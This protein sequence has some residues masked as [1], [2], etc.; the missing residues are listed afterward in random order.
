M[1]ILEAIGSWIISV[2][3]WIGLKIWAVF[4]YIYIFFMLILGTIGIVIGFIAGLFR[5][6]E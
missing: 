6:K 5:G 4:V 2:V 1:T 3:S